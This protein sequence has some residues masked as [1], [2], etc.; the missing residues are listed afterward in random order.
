MCVHES[1]RYHP[2][3]ILLMTEGCGSRVGARRGARRGRVGVGGICPTSDF[4]N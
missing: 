2:A 1:E 4:Y 3:R